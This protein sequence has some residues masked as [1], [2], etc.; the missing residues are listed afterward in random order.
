MTKRYRLTPSMAWRLVEGQ[1]FAVTREGTMH[2]IE[3]ESGVAIWTR[4]SQGDATVD[5]LVA[6]VSEQ[7]EVDEQTAR[8]DTEEFVQTLESLGVLEQ[9]NR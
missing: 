2:N 3:T 5:D 6:T 9:R 7:F 8:T 1:V 4:L